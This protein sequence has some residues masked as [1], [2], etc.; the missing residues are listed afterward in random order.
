MSI[1]KSDKLG[2]MP[3]KKLLITMSL[4]SIFS[5]LIQAMYNIVDSIYIAQLSGEALFA[6]GL[7]FP[8]QMASLSIG[9]GAAVGTN[10]LVAKR[11]G[12]KRNEHANQTATTGLIISFIHGIIC[13]IFGLLVS[14]AFLQMFTTDTNVIELGTSY[15]FIVMG[16]AFAPHVQIMAERILQ[17][18]GNMIIPMFTQLL[19]AIINIILDPIFIFGYFGVPAMGMKGA[20]IATVIGQFCGMSVM[21][22]IILNGKHDIKIKFK[23]FKFEKVVI[24]KIYKIGLPVMVMNAI[25]SVTTT[26]MNGILATISVAAVNT[27]SI[28][29]KVQSFVFMP[30]FGMTQGAMPIL[31][32]NY[33]AKN[34][35]RYVSTIKLMFI[36]SFV[37]MSLGT[38]IF[39]FFPQQLIS[40]FN[41]DEQLLSV[42][43]IALRI[44]SIHFVIAA[45]GIVMTTIFQSMGDGLISMVMSMLR[46]L[47]F[48]VP[49]AYIFAN[50]F[51]LNYVWFSFTIASLLNVII[52]APLCI[53]RVKK[54][55]R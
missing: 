2:L 33:G 10:A 9:I 15:L 38:I 50:Y 34:K 14:K 32:Y 37:I 18:T 1:N 36:A 12:Q 29:F 45:F 22:Y 20:A 25:G 28:Y 4:P 26:L 19:G 43:T 24:K 42:G 47:V 49:T 46:Q 11:L 30:I 5:M 8:I 35:E 39:M 51:G 31:A 52:F 6:I 41:P 17:A 48:I 23:G 16:F 40:M 54:A 7:V 27:L 21:L 55:F 3:I 13:A 44:I 53:K